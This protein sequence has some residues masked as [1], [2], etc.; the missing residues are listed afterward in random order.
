MAEDLKE[1]EAAQTVVGVDLDVV[2]VRLEVV[3]PAGNGFQ[4]LLGAD[5]VFDLALRLIAALARLKR[6]GEAGE[7]QAEPALTERQRRALAY[8]R[9]H[10]GVTA[11]SA[12]KTREASGNV[13]YDLVKLGHAEKRG[14][15]FY[16][17]N[18]AG[19]TDA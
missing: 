15:S 12:R 11:R 17:R 3:D 16:P 14:S 1:I 8:L 2:A 9:D 6:Y 7:A 10:P 5:E 19:G 4:A 13:L 18:A